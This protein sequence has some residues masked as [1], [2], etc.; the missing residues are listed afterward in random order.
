MQFVVG[1]VLKDGGV[2]GCEAGEESWVVGCV[3]F[4][5]DSW[6]GWTIERKVVVVSWV[7]G[8]SPRKSCLGRVH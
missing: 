7:D 4:A 8:N 6:N 5:T 1:Y 3:D 2:G